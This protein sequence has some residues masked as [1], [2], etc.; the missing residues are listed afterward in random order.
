MDKRSRI[1]DKIYDKNMTYLNVFSV[2]V[3]VPVPVLFPGFV[4]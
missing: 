4:L 3:P 1:I 2:P